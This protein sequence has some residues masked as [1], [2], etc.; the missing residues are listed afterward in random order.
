MPGTRWIVEGFEVGVVVQEPVA[1]AQANVE[2][3][4]LMLI[5][6]PSDTVESCIGVKYVLGVT[7]TDAAGTYGDKARRNHTDRGMFGR[8]GGSKRSER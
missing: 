6:P 4:G 2:I 1:V 7:E 5:D 8:N 3:L